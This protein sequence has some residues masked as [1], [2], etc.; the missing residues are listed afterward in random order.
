MK[1]YLSCLENVDISH[2]AQE[3][4]QQ[5]SSI[6]IVQKLALHKNGVGYPFFHL[7]LSLQKIA[8]LLIFLHSGSLCFIVFKHNFI[9]WSNLQL[10]FLIPGHSPVLNISQGVSVFIL[11]GK[12]QLVLL[13]KI[14]IKNLELTKQFSILQVLFGRITAPNQALKMSLSTVSVSKGFKQFCVKCPPRIYRGLT[15]YLLLYRG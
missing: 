1:C 13:L 5:L 2:E 12:I 3:I 7:F 15:S 4:P 9:L 10:H 8:C 11:I 6:F 14:M